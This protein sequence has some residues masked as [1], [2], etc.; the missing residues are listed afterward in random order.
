MRRPRASVSFQIK[1][2]KLKIK[3]KWSHNLFDAVTFE[4][5][6]TSLL[7][8]LACGAMAHPPAVGV[9]G[10]GRELHVLL[11]DPWGNTRTEVNPAALA[12]LYLNASRAAFP[13]GTW[14]TVP[15]PGRRRG[16]ARAGVNGLDIGHRG[17]NP[18]EFCHADTW[19]FIQNSVWRHKPVAASPAQES[20]AE[21]GHDVLYKRIKHHLW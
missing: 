5:A 3:N 8:H 1:K 20:A 2:K 11:V 7:L 18:A 15:A 4:T 16:P 21:P 17:P 12:T 19:R 10:G 9:S 14:V 13:A 6:S